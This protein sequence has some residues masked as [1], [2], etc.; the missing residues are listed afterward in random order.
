MKSSYIKRC[1]QDRVMKHLTHQKSDNLDKWLS[2]SANP[3]N[4]LKDVFRS[5]FKPGGQSAGGEMTVSN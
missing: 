1:R 4:K 3:A 5:Q 2:S